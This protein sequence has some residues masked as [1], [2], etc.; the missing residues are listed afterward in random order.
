MAARQPH[1]RQ[2]R[3][4]VEHAGDHLPQ[5]QLALPIR[6]QHGDDAEFARQ[7]RQQPDRPHRGTLDQFQPAFADGRHHAGQV[8][9]VPERQPDRLH[10]L[11]LAMREVGDRAMF[12][13]ARL[14]IGLA[15]QVA[16]VGLAVQPGGR[17]VYEHCDYE[18]AT[19][20]HQ[21][22]RLYDNY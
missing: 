5:R 4:L 16:G 13:L 7:L 21:K 8:R 19:E 1:R 18:F 6:A 15:Q 10:F 9:L 11:R 17:A 14:A 20:R 3:A 2:A 12:H 22:S